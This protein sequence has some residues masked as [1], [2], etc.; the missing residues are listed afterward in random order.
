MSTV[1]MTGIP[2]EHGNLSRRNWITVENIILLILIV[3][4]LAVIAGLVIA[5]IVKWMG[6]RD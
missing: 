6:M 4:A 2:G 5:R 3:I 1:G